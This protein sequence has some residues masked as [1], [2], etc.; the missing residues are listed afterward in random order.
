MSHMQRSG[1]QFGRSPP[2]N[3]YILIIQCLPFVS[4]AITLPV[5][6]QEFHFAFIYFFFNSA[7]AAQPFFFIKLSVLKKPDSFCFLTGL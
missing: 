4:P 2:P 7:S 5:L 1:S 6:P 3:I